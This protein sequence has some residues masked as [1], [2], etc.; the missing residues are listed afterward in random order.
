MPSGHVRLLGLAA[1]LV[2][3]GVCPPAVTAA[4]TAVP[5]PAAIPGTRQLTLTGAVDLG[6]VAPGTLDV[7]IV[8]PLRDRGGAEALAVAVHRPG[9]PAYLRFLAAGEFASRF[10]ADP[11][12]VAAVST[13]ARR[14]GLQVVSVSQ[15]RTL[16]RLRG[17]SP[18]VESAFG[19]RL[20]RFR[21]PAFDYTATLG[22]A[23][24]PAALAGRVA[25]V[26]GLGDLGRLEP[27]VRLPADP[28]L[29]PGDPPPLPRPSV[30]LSHYGPADLWRF[31]DAPP[32]F[33]GTGQAIAVMAAGDVSHARRDLALFE[34]R[35]G[36]PPVRWTT[37][38][39]G[40]PSTD[41]AGS[42]EW[43]L[44][45][46]VSTGLAPDAADL[47]VY[48]TTSLSGGDIAAEFARW[49]ADD[50]AREASASFGACE[51]LAYLTGII[52]A[53]DPVLLQAV[54]QGQSLFAASGDSGS[55][56]PAVIGVNGIPLGLPGP[57]YPASSPSAI[58]VGGTTITGQQGP[59]SELAWKAGG[60]GIS[61]LEL[62]PGYQSGAGGSYV[63]VGRG[64]PDVSL[65]ADPLTGYSVVMDGK[66]LI[67]GGT[68]ASAPAW[69][70]IWARAQQAR[71]GRLG[72]ANVALY[73][74]PAR[75]FHDVVA[76]SQVLHAATPGWDY[77]TGRGTP[78]IA[79]LLQVL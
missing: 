52:E 47:L 61:H 28:P 35:Q 64:V 5:S 24:L 32:A 19:V 41:L 22:D 43:D 73:R 58:G 36:L 21:G 48:D 69:L 38:Q 18:S 15:S 78:D 45:T 71:G 51:S 68:S 77:C 46:Q 4:P 60:G 6:P 66:D 54:A 79:V 2:L 67:V 12:V 50:R 29:P 74:A 8:L 14:S 65:D 72:F 17:P 1:A 13:W 56:C 63:G 53:L 62:P 55:F 23:R 9:D 26:L 20:H 11:G 49:V 76:G 75:A 70:G 57:L 3:L 25:A 16:V 37:I 40:A 59:L 7:T 10:G 34:S 27:S 30:H 42:P 44:D 33:R 31:Y 39:V